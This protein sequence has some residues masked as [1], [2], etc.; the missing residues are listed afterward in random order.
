MVRRKIARARTRAGLAALAGDVRK[1]KPRKRSTPS[2][3]S[4]PRLAHPEQVVDFK[5]EIVEES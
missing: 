4:S 3:I 2:R 5:M 1:K